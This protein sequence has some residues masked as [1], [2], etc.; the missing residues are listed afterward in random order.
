MDAFSS[1][2][3]DLVFGVGSIGPE[4]WCSHGHR[5]RSSETADPISI[6]AWKP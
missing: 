5:R 1:S 2:R 3:R 4:P 6:A